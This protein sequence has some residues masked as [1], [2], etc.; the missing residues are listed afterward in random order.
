MKERSL[1]YSQITDGLIIGRTPR[2]SD[3]PRLREEGITLLINMRAERY[4][5]PTKGRR[6]IETLW[7]PTFDHRRL[8]IRPTTIHEPA[9]RAVDEIE[10]GGKV[11]AYCRA[12]RHRSVLM[13]A[14][15]L[16]GLDY[17]IEASTSLIKEGRPVADPDIPHIQNAIL[18]Y[19]AYL[20]EQ[21]MLL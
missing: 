5:I 4:A 20:A 11:Y 17:D 10:Q 16:I 13:G 8:P 21:N 7:V 14:A 19:S 9:Q 2:R 1:D 6:S 3:Y 18:E 12:G 15:I